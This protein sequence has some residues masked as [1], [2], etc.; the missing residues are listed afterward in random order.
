MSAY[1]LE[2]NTYFF[3]KT[4]R[5]ARYHCR[6]ESSATIFHSRTASIASFLR[7]FVIEKIINQ[8]EVTNGRR[9]VQSCAQSIYAATN[10]ANLDALSNRSAS[11]KK[12]DSPT[13]R[14]MRNVAR[15]QELV[16]A[17]LLSGISHKLCRHQFL[18]TIDLLPLLPLQPVRSYFL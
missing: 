13:M 9:V 15:N 8:N 5:F 17:H 14:K 16:K 11:V 3:P 7:I 1:L 18:Q 12:G 6:R 2:Q 10:L 4:F